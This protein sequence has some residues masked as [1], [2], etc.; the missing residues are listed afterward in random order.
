MIFESP[1]LKVILTFL[2]RTVLFLRVLFEQTCLYS[3]EQ[4]KLYY[5]ERGELESAA[6]PRRKET[7]WKV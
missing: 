5:C 4:G 6:L 3:C 1:S 2:Q 7:N